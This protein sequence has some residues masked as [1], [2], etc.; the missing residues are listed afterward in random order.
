MPGQ[1][2]NSTS[3]DS[4]KGRM[5]CSATREATVAELAAGLVGIPD[6]RRKAILFR[7]GQ[8]P[9][10][11]VRRYGRAVRGKSIR[12]AVSAHCYE[13]VQWIRSEVG[14]CTSLGCSLWPYRPEQ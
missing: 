14:L 9:K 4:A 6:N 1:P 11:F 5:A 2:F 8:M 13:C 3:L 7:A 12:A 10:G